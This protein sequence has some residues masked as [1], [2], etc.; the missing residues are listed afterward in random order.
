[1]LIRVFIQPFYRTIRRTP[2]YSCLLL[3]YYSLVLY[4]KQNFHGFHFFWGL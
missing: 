2:Y 1:M 4:S 3:V